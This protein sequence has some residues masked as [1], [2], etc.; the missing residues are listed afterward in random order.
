MWLLRDG[1]EATIRHLSQSPIRI[2]SCQ[3]PSHLQPTHSQENSFI[4]RR[5]GRAVGLVVALLI[6]RPARP[7]E[8]Q[9]KAGEVKSLVKPIHLLSSRPMPAQPQ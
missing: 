8:S 5:R 3:L 7:P 1:F 6:A 2:I 9:V 4:V